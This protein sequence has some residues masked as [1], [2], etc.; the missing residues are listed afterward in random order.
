[1]AAQ[2]KKYKLT[3]IVFKAIY[4]KIHCRN[5]NQKIKVSQRKNR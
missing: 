1:L 2:C 5:Q 4:C 3:N